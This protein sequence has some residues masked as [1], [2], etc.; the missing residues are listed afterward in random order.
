M[1]APLPIDAVLPELI[2]VLSHN[3]NVVLQA[4]AGAGK[5]TRVPPALLQAQLAN[6]GLIV[7]IEPRRLAAQ[8]AARRM[9]TEHDQRVGE[10][11]G[12][13]IRFDR[14]AG[15]ATRVLVVT[16][17]V[18]LRMLLDDPLLE[19]VAV[20]VFDEF[21]ERNLNS[22]LALAIARQLQTELRPEL[23]LVVMSAT[24]DPQPIADYLGCPIVASGGKL[25]PVDVRYLPLPT[26]RPLPQ[27]VASGVANLLDSTAGD[28]LAFLPGVGEIRRTHEQLLPL[29]S[30]RQL[31]VH[32]LYGDLPMDQQ[33]AALRP[34]DRRKV[35]LST[36]VA[37][38]SVT[39]EGITA[40]VDS[41][42]A[43]VL[44]WD[45]S[46]G[47]DRL[48]VERIS[49]SSAD[50]R[51][52]RAGRTA[53]GICLR[54]WTQHE[55]RFLAE[56]N[57]PEVL[58]LDLSGALLTLLSRGE[59]RWENFPWYEAPRAAACEQASTLLR[60]LGAADGQG[61]TELGKTLAF[62]P[63]HPRLGCL[64]VEGF[65]HDCPDRA[66]L[67]AA[68]LTE[69]DPFARDGQRQAQHASSSDLLDRIQALEEFAKARILDST[70]GRLNATAAQYVLHVRQQLLRT[71][72]DA[73]LVM[74]ASSDRRPDSL[75]RAIAAALPDRIARR[76]E[77]GS[78]RGIMVGG[79]GVR[80]S[81]RSAV[82]EGE[83]FACVEIE[84]IGGAES[85]VRQASSVDRSWLPRQLI[86]EDVVARFDEQRERVL[87]VRRTLYED[88]VLEE[89]QIE[90]GDPDVIARVLCEAAAKQLDHALP[91]RAENVA[92]FLARVRSLRQWMPH[93]NLPEF[94]TAELQAFLPQLCS[95]RRSFDELRSAPLL[96]YLQSAL[97]SQQLVAL[98][99]EAPERIAA[100]SGSRIRLY[101]EPGRPPVMAVRI[102]EMFGQLDTPR[103]AGGRVSIL[104]HLLAPNMRPQQ[105]TDDLRS[106]WE[107]GYPTI[108]KELRRR[109]PKHS[110]PEDPLQ[111]SPENRPRPR[112]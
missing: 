82:H 32:E 94:S 78:R 26:Q 27:S 44:R 71:A 38:T 69:R 108:R 30:D 77:P 90:A 49:R 63:L 11:F 42:M 21:H 15:L 19:R 103:I 37:E 53:P 40:V 76:R 50:Q 99:R 52:G 68:L 100:A 39:I 46:V 45:P 91:L 101:Y 60:R 105:I 54:L 102:Q 13:H 74:S 20:I 9:A 36:N 10:T 4:P 43:R 6:D 88:L 98:N 110:W 84:E 25:F 14:R 7:V 109:Y 22:D 34:A 87:I 16:E 48:A 28:I 33:D 47:I 81:D 93:L 2:K 97:T 24:I 55:H 75:L 96:D 12:Y 104:L 72:R 92:Q 41:G 57:T 18:L 83:L 79:R 70:A 106:F 35:I 5:T 56:R 51:A 65:R 89:S 73:G 59:T 111:A 66:A 17:G 29:A 31:V 64:L 80:L 107:R 62:L 1:L 85:L 67:A 95:G 23:K 8:T 3:G 58:R 86:S 61:L 112:S